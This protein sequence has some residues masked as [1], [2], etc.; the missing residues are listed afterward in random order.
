M[1]EVLTVALPQDPA[2]D[3]VLAALSAG[4]AQALVVGGAVRNTLLGEPVSDI[5]IATSARPEDT[6]RLARAAGLRTV[7][8][9]IDHG[10]VT[11][12][13]DGRGYEVTTFR[14]DVETDGRR[15]VV[16][17]SDDIRD[18]ARRRDFTMNALYATATGRIVDPVG[19][20]PDLASRKLRFVGDARD[21]IREDYLRILRFFRFLAW[22]GREADLQALAAC[23][24]LRGGLA[25]ISRERIGHEMRKLL[26]A[27]DPAHA[28]R[29]MAE[30]GV[31]PL[32]LPG[33]D[34]GDL[35][36]LIEAEQDFGAG[37]LPIWPRRLALLGA[38]NATEALRLSRD[39]TRMQ[40]QLAE[41]QTLSPAAAAYRFGPA[42]AAQSVLIR[43]AHDDAPAFGWCHE[44][45]RGA[46]M[47]FPLSAADLMPDVK[48]AALGRGLQRAERA[49]IDSDFTL[50]RD[51]LRDIARD[52]APD[53]GKGGTVDA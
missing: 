13:A 8:T 28:V 44:I 6:I 4:G 30:A 51:Q 53:G 49:W 37:A 52:P 46:G 5:D 50:S 43:T 21:R 7:P 45:A 33:A 15:A 27:P 35:P 22:Y 19:G 2:L 39:E 1:T 10:T 47:T 29:L 48:G 18:D 34:A 12:I 32:I 31:L 25:G 38:P 17:F 26:S 11:V 9:G 20:L 42:I 40:Q 23:H 24:E 36:E 16:A 14:R 41:A 3:R